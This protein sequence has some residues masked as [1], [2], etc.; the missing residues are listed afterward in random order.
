MFDLIR[1]RLL[2]ELAHRGTMTAVAESLGM[3]S[4]AVSQQLATL[5]Y[6]ARAVLLERIGR[7][8]QLTAA[9]ER[10]VAHADIILQAVDAAELDLR[11]AGEQPK[12]VIRI[13]SFPTFAK[14]RL[15][16]AIKQARARFPDLDVILY[17]IESAEAP[18]AV[19]DGRCDLAVVFSYNLAPQPDPAGVISHYLLE[20][21][22]LLALGP[23]W[24]R[25]SGPVD[26]RRLEKEKWI[27]GSRQLDDHEIALRACALAGFVPEIT[28]RIDD[29]DLVLRLVAA[30]IGVG[31][32]PEMALSTSA[33]KGIVARP[34]AGPAIMRRLSAV[35][36]PTLANAPTIRAIL[37]ALREPAEATV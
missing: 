31:F 13:G 5:E 26:L 18:A 15:L 24:R 23:K 2:R 32:V 22:V 19:R 30:G 11:A 29:Y 6:E 12:G 4:S 1:L 17:E 3:T 36:R 10:L 21:P 28:H 25:D 9:G 8:V 34:P 37:S 16:P 33:I 7:R 27:V 14:A 20:E 35:T